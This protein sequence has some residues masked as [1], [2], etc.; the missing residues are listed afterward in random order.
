MQADLLPESFSLLL[1]EVEM[2]QHMK[3]HRESLL[4][5]LDDQFIKHAY[6]LFV[7]VRVIVKTL[8]Y[9]VAND[10]HKRNFPCLFNSLAESGLR[11]FW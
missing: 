9:F 11:F 6:Q 8:Q 10:L 1:A 3:D 2:G 4:T 5:E 7:V